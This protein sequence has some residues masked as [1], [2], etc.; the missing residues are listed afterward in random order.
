MTDDAI[1]V[2]QPQTDQGRWLLDHQGLVNISKPAHHSMRGD[3]IDLRASVLAIEAE[4]R[5]EA[6]PPSLDVPEWLTAA[7]DAYVT[8][9]GTEYVAYERAKWQRWHDRAAEEHPLERR[10]EMLVCTSCGAVGGVGDRA[11]DTPRGCPRHPGLDAPGCHGC[12]MTNHSQSALTKPD[13]AAEEGHGVS[14]LFHHAAGA[15]CVVCD[16]AAEKHS[17]IP[18]V[19]TTPDPQWPALGMTTPTTETGRRHQADYRPHSPADWD[20]FDASVLTIE[21][22]AVAEVAH[23]ADRL[24]AAATE[25]VNHWAGQHI[26]D[27]QDCRFDD[28]M[29]DLGAAAA[30]TDRAAEE[31]HTEF[32]WL[33]E[34]G[35][36]ERQVPTVWWVDEHRW[37]SD[38]NK[39][40]RFSARAA[41]QE[42]I[43]LTLTP[44]QARYGGPSA[45]AV[46]HVF[47]TDRAAEEGR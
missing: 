21:A 25:A 16:R 23:K 46:E 15:L 5:A 24:R 20:E 45:R 33:I 37:T 13:R 39:A 2:A 29:F 9:D 32:V 17:G 42:V 44:P 11:A 18:P 38:A 7:P 40:F 1:E 4:A 3:E 36:P 30:L 22:E 8:V 35:Q 47:L 28:H 10:G 14:G 34:R 6:T 27:E 26:D 31:G 19:N 12:W 43:G 41:A